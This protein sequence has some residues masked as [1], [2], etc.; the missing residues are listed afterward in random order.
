MTTQEHTK[1][2][3]Y[4]NEWAGRRNGFMKDSRNQLA[5]HKYGIKIYCEP[6]NSYY[7]SKKNTKAY[8]RIVIDDQGRLKKGEQSYKQGQEVTDKMNELYAVYADRIRRLI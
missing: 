3:E 7:G 5:C 2:W 6:L 4:W 8:V 1:N